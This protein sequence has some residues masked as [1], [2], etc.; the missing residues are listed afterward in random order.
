[1]NDILFWL[2]A[3]GLLIVAAAV[4]IYAGRHDRGPRHPAE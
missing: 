1:M 2:W 4:A 3:P